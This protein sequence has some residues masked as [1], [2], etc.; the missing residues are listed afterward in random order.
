MPTTTFQSSKNDKKRGKRRDCPH[1]YTTGS[2]SGNKGRCRRN[3]NK[4][5]TG[6]VKKFELRIWARLSLY[7]TNGSGDNHLQTKVKKFDILINDANF[8][9]ETRTSSIRQR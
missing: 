1:D 4:Q 3:R 5:L 9:C 6:A 8:N 2:K 7:Q